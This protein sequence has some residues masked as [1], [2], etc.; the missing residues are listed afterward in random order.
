[1]ILLSQIMNLT[2]EP[3][4]TIAKNTR[5]SATWITTMKAYLEK[6]TRAL[7]GWRNMLI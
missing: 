3:F 5:K 1:M 4:K 6:M 2:M 7:V